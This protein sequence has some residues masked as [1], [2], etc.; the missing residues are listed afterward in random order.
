MNNG[1]DPLARPAL[2]GEEG[3]I[4]PFVAT[5]SASN[6]PFLRSTDSSRPPFRDRRAFT[7]LLLLTVI[8]SVAI[9][10]A[11]WL[12]YLIR[13][14]FHP[15]IDE[16]AHF[17]RTLQWT[18]PVELL[19]LLSFGQFRSLLSYFSLPDARRIVLA[20]GSAS[21]VSLGV[22]YA[23][24][25][26]YA[27][28]RS[29]IILGFLL[30]SVAL[31]SVRLSFRML[32]EGQ[33]GS[34]R[35]DRP[36]RRIV[37]IGAGDVGANLAKEMKLRRDLRMYPIAFFDDDRTKW[38]THIHGVPVVGRPELLTEGKIRAD[39]AV[40]AMPSASGRRIRE[41]VQVFNEV[42]LRF[43]TVPSMEQMVNGVVKASQIRPV[44]IED[45]LGRERINLETERIRE[46]VSRQSG[47]G[48][49][50]RRK[51]WQRIVPADRGVSSFAPTACGAL[52]GAD[53]PD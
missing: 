4:P 12:A 39:E 31:G 29:I 2:H 49:R 3:S 40:I 19:A 38:N 27:P 46:L 7:R 32:R 14:E 13:F 44:E 23:T 21:I 42:H 45:L 43:E 17:W 16:R 53:V 30:D 48:H 8:Y 15:P 5:T 28:S 26:Q 24:N 52:R 37:I 33:K 47:D 11:H 22:W 20:C 50:G 25:G 1:G 6:P 35:S 9:V 41:V 51:H 36:L 34:A 10:V 18:L